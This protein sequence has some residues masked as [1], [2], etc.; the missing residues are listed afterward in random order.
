MASYDQKIKIRAS[1]REEA[2]SFFNFLQKVGKKYL[3]P[4]KIKYRYL[5]RGYFYIVI[6]GG[7]GG[8]DALFQE[9]ILNRGLYYYACT[10]KNKQKIISSVIYQYIK[11]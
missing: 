9:L 2:R 6:D 11:I 1:F 4:V 5:G 3:R 7:S 10:L 8:I